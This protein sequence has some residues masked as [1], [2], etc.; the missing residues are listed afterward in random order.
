MLTPEKQARLNSFFT[1]ASRIANVNVNLEKTHD[2]YNLDIE[3]ANSIKP[4][5]IERLNL[6]QDILSFS[7]IFDF[8]KIKVPTEPLRIAVNSTGVT[9]TVIPTEQYTFIVN[10]TISNFLLKVGNLLPITLINNFNAGNFSDCNLGITVN[11]DVSASKSQVYVT[12]SVDLSTVKGDLFTFYY[13]NTGSLILGFS[14]KSKP[15]TDPSYYSYYSAPQ[16][17]FNVLS[18]QDKMTF[19]YLDPLGY[20]R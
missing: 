17:A 18:E 8:I 3:V 9:V 14:P 1:Y 10:E 20:N 2:R 15:Y 16:Q 11:S 12:D 5:S 13:L 4:L 6:V 7:D 19:A